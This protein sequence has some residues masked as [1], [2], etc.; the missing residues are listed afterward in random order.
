MTLDADLSLSESRFKDDALEGD[1]I[2]G[3]VETVFTTGIALDSGTGFSLK[4]ILIHCAQYSSSLN[5]ASI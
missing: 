4:N 5:Q 3:S 2:P 1:H